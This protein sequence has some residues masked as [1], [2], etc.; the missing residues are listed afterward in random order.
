MTV[1]LLPP[2]TQ[3]LDT[4]LGDIML[5]PLTYLRILATA[6][7][8]EGVPPLRINGVAFE[9]T[10][11]F[12]LAAG[13]WLLQRGTASLRRADWMLRQASTWRQGEA[14]PAAWRKLREVLEARLTGYL[15]TPD[16]EMLLERGEYVDKQNQFRATLT[17]IHDAE[18]RLDELRQKAQSLRRCLGGLRQAI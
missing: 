3:T 8:G 6:G 17:A 13:R 15:K 10:G 11:Q 1:H 4:R 7:P 18:Q 14:S 2:P 9:F 12:E 16:G 5:Q